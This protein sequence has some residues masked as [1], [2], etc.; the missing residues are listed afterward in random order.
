MSKPFLKIYY[1]PNSYDEELMEFIK[2]YATE[3]GQ[4]YTE[5]VLEILRAFW[6]PIILQDM[7]VKPFKLKELQGKSIALL[8]NQLELLGGELPINQSFINQEVDT[9][10]DED[11][12][13]IE[14]KS[15]DTTIQFKKLSY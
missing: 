11:D 12:V 5:I 13:E 3:R 10:N 2:N 1:A 6:L 14:K 9:E 7:N 8:K 15:F 4:S